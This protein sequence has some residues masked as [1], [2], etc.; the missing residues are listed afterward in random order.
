MYPPPVPHT[1]TS[2]PVLVG[3]SCVHSSL[4]MICN[5]QVCKLFTFIKS[6]ISFE[7][8]DGFGAGM[9]GRIGF[10]S[11]LVISSYIFVEELSIMTADLAT[12]VKPVRNGFLINPIPVGLIFDYFF[13]GGDEGSSKA[14]PPPA[15]NFG[16]I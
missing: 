12:A 10:A 13:L 9:M 5:L 6:S 14:L 16:P 4:F 8:S 7:N 11:F 2:T 3:L 1:T 15:S